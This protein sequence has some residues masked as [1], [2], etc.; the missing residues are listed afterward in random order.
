MFINMYPIKRSVNKLKHT[1]THSLSTGVIAVCS[2]S[3]SITSPAKWL[4]PIQCSNLVC[5][6]PTKG[7]SV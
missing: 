2:D 6:A 3:L 4:T 5:V 1:W 7:I